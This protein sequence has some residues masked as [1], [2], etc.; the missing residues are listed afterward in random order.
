[1]RSLNEVLTPGKT[2]YDQDTRYSIYRE[3]DLRRA[4]ERNQTIRC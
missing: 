2:D 3:R 1:M 4:A